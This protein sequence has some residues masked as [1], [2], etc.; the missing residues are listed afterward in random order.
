MCVVVYV[1][2]MITVLMKLLFS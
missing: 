2:S 1:V